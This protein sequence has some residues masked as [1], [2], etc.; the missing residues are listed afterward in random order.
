MNPDS[1]NLKMD[2]YF[3]VFEGMLNVVNHR[4]EST[5]ISLSEQQQQ[6]QGQGLIVNYPEL[7]KFIVSTTRLKSFDTI[8]KS[9]TIDGE[10]LEVTVDERLAILQDKP[11]I[12]AIPTS[13]QGLAQIS[14]LSNLVIQGT[15]KPDEIVADMQQQHQQQ[16]Q[17]QQQLE[18]TKLPSSTNQPM[19]PTIPIN[20]QYGSRAKNLLDSI[21]NS[22]DT[23]VLKPNAGQYSVL[24]RFATYFDFVDYKDHDQIAGY[25]KPDKEIDIPRIFLEGPA[26]TGKS[27][28]FVL[29]EKL[30]HSIERT[31]SI[32]CSTGV[33]CSAVKTQTGAR[34]TNSLF[35]FGINPDDIKEQTQARKVMMFKNLNKNPILVIVDEIGFA[36]ASVLQ[37]INLRLKD[38]FPLCNDDFGGKA[39]IFA[40]DFYQLPPVA[41]K[42]PIYKAALVF[43]DEYLVT[44]NN[45][46]QNQLEGK[47]LFIKLIKMSLTEQMRVTDQDLLGW[48]NKLRKGNATGLGNYLKSQLLKAND[49]QFSKPGDVM[50]I[51][52]GNPERLHMDI[53]Q[54]KKF[55][56]ANNERVISWPLNAY[57]INASERKKTKPKKHQGTKFHA[58][59]KGKSLRKMITELS[60]DE[61]TN[62][63]WN[64]NPVLNAH[65]CK[66]APIFM[67][68]NINPI[69]GLAN[70]VKGTL[71]ALDWDTTE[72]R[73]DALAYINAQP[74]TSHVTLPEN[75]IPSKIYIIPELQGEVKREWEA[76]L[77]LQKAKHLEN[78]NV[79]FDS[80]T[81]DPT[82]QQV[83]IS[84]DFK[85][86]QLPIHYNGKT[87]WV[88]IEKPQFDLG[89]TCTIHKAQGATLDRVIISFLQ[90]PVSPSPKDFHAVYVALTR[91]R[92]KDCLRIIAHEDELDFLDYLAPNIELVAFMEGYDDEGKWNKDIAVSKI[93]ELRKF[94]TEKE[95]KRLL[96]KT[97]AK[98]MSAKE[99][100]MKSSTG[101]QV[102]HSDSITGSGINVGMGTITGSATPTVSAMKVKEKSVVG[103]SSVTYALNTI[104]GVNNFLEYYKDEI[105]ID[106]IMK[107]GNNVEN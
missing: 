105:P 79:V 57:V 49:V 77:E 56:E 97:Q 40:G 73:I 107:A 50:V 86:T 20:Q 103:S 106:E 18:Q 94:E 34:T 32:S 66:G 5:N 63:L 13:E 7:G 17:Q 2:K 76:K 46:S 84:I 96:E 104:V 11:I 10:D 101:V 12:Q 6:R 28:I 21:M 24:Q 71:Y 67:N 80:C 14:H 69:K 102:D 29:L 99:R 33:A 47:N 37:A 31:I 85:N 68:Q 70:G 27:F 90:R 48:I 62:V 89:F 83:V 81:L 88:N 75:L 19:V 58:S 95:K 30:A 72:K 98:I 93:V 3:A 61:G 74:L 38:C 16:Q 8:L 39:M 42:Y 59:H 4:K 43:K 41:C 60:N 51:S 1:A 87:I 36:K 64:S 22:T 23:S 100:K 52:P 53:I 91:I 55:A 54:I 78:P 82:F 26:G 92:S 15:N 25:V 35:N 9:D 65:F 44:N 45:G